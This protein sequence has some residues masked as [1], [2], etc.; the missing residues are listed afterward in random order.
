MLI[1]LPFYKRTIT[2]PF[3]LFYMPLLVVLG[4]L[5]ITTTPCIAEN[6]FSIQQDQIRDIGLIGNQRENVGDV[7]A[8][9]LFY[10]ARSQL[11]TSAMTSSRR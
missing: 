3:R 2:N 7:I 11:N 8:E 1:S 9:Q 4:I 6:S 10:L 5:A